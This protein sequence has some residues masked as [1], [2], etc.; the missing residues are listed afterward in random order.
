MRAARPTLILTGVLAILVAGI[1]Y[2]QP[3]AGQPIGERI[4]TLNNIEAF[5]LSKARSQR[6]ELE[7]ARA[8]DPDLSFSVPESLRQPWVFD[9]TGPRRELEKRQTPKK[10]REEIEKMRKA[11]SEDPDFGECKKILWF[12]GVSMNHAHTKEMQ[13]KF[14]WFQALNWGFKEK[15]DRLQGLKGAARQVAEKELGMQVEL[16]ER[17]ASLFFPSTPAAPS[18]PTSAEPRKKPAKPPDWSDY[19]PQLP[20]TLTPPGAASGG[21]AGTP[22]KKPV[23][24]KMT[25]FASGL[26]F[27]MGLHYERLEDATHK[28]TLE[29]I[30]ARAKKSFGEGKAGGGGVSLH[31]PA[32]VEGGLDTASISR[33][34]VENDRLILLLK[35]GKR[36][37]MPKLPP[38]DLAV[39]MRTIFGPN[40][41]LKGKLTAIDGEA[42]ALKTGKDQFGDVVWRLSNLPTPW[43]PVKVGSETGLAIPPGLGLLEL[44]EPS[45]GRITFYGDMKNTRLGS[46][47]SRADQLLIRFVNGVDPKTGLMV[48]PPSIPGYMNLQEI[49]A[50]RKAGI[51]KLKQ[52]GKSKTAPPPNPDYWWRGSTWFVWVPGVVRLEYQPKAGEV[53]VAETAIRLDTWISVGTVGAEVV[54]LRDWINAN[55]GALAKTYPVLAEL[56]EVATTVAIVRWLKVNRIATDIDWATARSVKKVPTPER[57][58]QTHVYFVQDNKGMPIF[59]ATGGGRAK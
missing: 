58:P 26:L 31:L 42:I 15:V 29:R 57:V 13:T 46:V 55:I 51:L 1:A 10:R 8:K 18:K 2:A 9:P 47:M 3:G 33:A 45:L 7:R 30:L 14:G 40:R 25:G 38:D 43:R 6:E 50:L 28:R 36:V 27:E 23:L 37:R 17:M 16:A 11:G 49:L 34:V 53:R 20:K 12:Y 19:K 41:L 56:R 59:R 44:P 22:G 32:K 35:D 24:T 4:S 39:A 48:E 54:K 52:P 5:L 21:A